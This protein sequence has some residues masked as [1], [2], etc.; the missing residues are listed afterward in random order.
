MYL[1][2]STSCAKERI[3]LK[4]DKSA[5]IDCEK[6]EEGCFFWQESLTF[7]LFSLQ[8]CQKFVIYIQSYSYDNSTEKLD[9]RRPY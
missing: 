3:G 2:I 1:P 4:A 5:V 7:L 6:K 8:N 9:Y